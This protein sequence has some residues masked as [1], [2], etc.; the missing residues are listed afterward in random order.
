MAKKHVYSA[1][2]DFKTGFLYKLS[3]V[4][5]CVLCVVY[6]VEMLLH[7]L[8]LSPDTL[9]TLLAFVILGFG[10]GAILYFFSRQFAKLS[11]IADDVEHDESLDDSEEAEEHS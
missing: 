8:G 2:S 1:H 6:V 4:I 10:L 9:G 11:D 3:F 5:A 7:P